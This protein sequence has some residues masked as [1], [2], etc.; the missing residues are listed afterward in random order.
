M[1]SGTL[2]GIRDKTEKDVPENE[3]KRLT[4]QA[5]QAKGKEL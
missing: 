3:I 5:S 4:M 1:F 2:S